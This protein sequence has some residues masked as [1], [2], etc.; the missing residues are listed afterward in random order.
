[1]RMD[2]G[3]LKEKIMEKYSEKS[4]TEEKELVWLRKKVKAGEEIDWA[5]VD[6]VDY[7]LDS[8]PRRR[9]LI[10]EFKARPKEV[11]EKCLSLLSW[12]KEP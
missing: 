9:E 6:T 5:F 4:E 11:K 7:E 3:K 10:L 1:M 8:L 2:W 12:K